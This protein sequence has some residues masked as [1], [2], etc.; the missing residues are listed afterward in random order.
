MSNSNSSFVPRNEHDA[1]AFFQDNN[2]N[3][4]AFGGFDPALANGASHH[5]DLAFANNN[6][7]GYTPEQVGG[8]NHGH[9]PQ[10]SLYPGW[11][12]SSHT[13]HELNFQPTPDS[14]N[15]FHGNSF[16]QQS[17][18]SNGSGFDGSNDFRYPMQSDFGMSN[19]Y[20]AALAGNTFQS[21]SPAPY[22]QPPSQ[23]N[24]ISPGALQSRPAS[25]LN[26]SSSMPAPAKREV[27]LSDSFPVITLVDLIAEPEA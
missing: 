3:N 21:N 17:G 8:L 19:G 26:A 27:R 7:W 13:Q 25:Y 20:N 12:N 1:H 24:T 15:G 16:A 9:D 23:L 4:N 14:F 18:T 22:S 6:S 11:H 2:F 5:D 10:A